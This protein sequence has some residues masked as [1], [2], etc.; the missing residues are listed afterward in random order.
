MRAMPLKIAQSFR[1]V[2][3]ASAVFFALPV[4]ANEGP[5][6]LLAGQL[7]AAADC[8]C[9]G[10]ADCTCKKGQCKCSKCGKHNVKVRVFDALKGNPDPSKLPETARFDAT[11]GVFI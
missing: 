10:K 5:R 11:A 1:L 7:D 9:S 4:A 6:S 3:I 2:A 8:G